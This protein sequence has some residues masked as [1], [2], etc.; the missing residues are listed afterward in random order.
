MSLS[1][2][3]LTRIQIDCDHAWQVQ[4]ELPMLSS[5][6]IAYILPRLGMTVDEAI[7]AYKRFGEIVF[8]QKPLAGNAGKLILG[9]FSKAF[10]STSKLQEVLKTVVTEANVDVNESFLGHEAFGLQNVCHS[11]L[12]ALHS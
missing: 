10:Y 6:F 9:A 11:Y 1:D 8:G 12:K 5:S 2:L 7:V 3:T 4:P